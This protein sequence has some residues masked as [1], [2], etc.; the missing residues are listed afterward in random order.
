MTLACYSARAGAAFLP[1]ENNQWLRID[2]DDPD[3]LQPCSAWELAVALRGCTDVVEMP[4]DDVEEVHV[5][6]FHAVELMNASDLTLWLLDSTLPEETRALAA[7]ELNGFLDEPGLIESWKGVFWWK[8]LGKDAD[9][10]NAL[11]IASRVKALMVVFHLEDLRNRQVAIKHVRD[12]LEAV[13]ASDAVAQSEV[14]KARRRVLKQRQHV[15]IVHA[16]CELQEG[17]KT[18]RLR[19]FHSESDHAED[20]LISKWWAKCVQ[21]LPF[22][23]ESS[24]STIE[25]DIKDM[26]IR[27]VRRLPECDTNV[28]EA[29]FKFLMF[30]LER[31]ARSRL[32]TA[33]KRVQDEEDLLAEVYAELLVAG[34]QNALP[35]IESLEDLLK[36][37]YFRLQRRAANIHRYENVEN[38]GGKEEPRD[39]TFGWGES[40]SAHASFESVPDDYPSPHSRLL[41]ADDL[42]EI[43]AKISNALG[44]NSLILVYSL[45]AAGLTKEEISR[46]CQLSPS[47]VD[48]KLELILRRL[49]EACFHSPLPKRL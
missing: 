26:I 42:Q 37:L 36:L 49:Q 31:R 45:W 1:T 15:A 43:H 40:D 9:L 12:Q 3:T 17:N 13:L 16:V 10:E 35:P 41:R 30:K 48:C 2:A 18:K 23:D 27:L 4:A 46:A 8:P 33:P 19:N 39:S 20:S 28:S 25:T 24:G 38:S 29:L 6:L 21:L 44:D 11:E 47:I 32:A 14:E 22:H 34:E 7:R 5:A